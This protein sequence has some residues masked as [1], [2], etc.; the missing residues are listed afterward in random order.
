MKP[1]LVPPSFAA[2]QNS[3][4]WVRAFTAP[5]GDAA[6]HLETYL[7]RVENL[8]RSSSHEDGGLYTIFSRAHRGSYHGFFESLRIKNRRGILARTFE[9][10]TAVARFDLQPKTEKKYRKL[11]K[12]G[13]GSAGL[14]RAHLVGNLPQAGPSLVLTPVRTRRRQL[15]PHDHDPHHP[16]L[17]APDDLCSL[18]TT[19]R[20]PGRFGYL[21][22]LEN[23]DT[24]GVDKPGCTAVPA[25]PMQTCHVTHI[26]L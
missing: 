2:P 17:Q 13:L 20:P 19:P 15:Q 9:H 7:T 1:T 3:F 5:I 14:R 11:S 6:R 26:T 25:W 8:L 23:L 4:P 22:N 16:A 18:P 21:G 12:Y 10:L 24:F